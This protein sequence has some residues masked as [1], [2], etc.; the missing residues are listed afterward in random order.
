M[1]RLL[2]LIFGHRWAHLRNRH[3]NGYTTYYFYCQRCKKRRHFVE[4]A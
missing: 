1:K 2:C 4:A 3:K